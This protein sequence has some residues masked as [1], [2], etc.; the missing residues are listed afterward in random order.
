MSEKRTLCGIAAAFRYTWPGWDEAYA[1]TYHA[2]QIARIAH[3]MGF[4]LQLVP[5]APRDP[6]RTC[7]QMVQPDD[8]N[9]RFWKKAVEAG[10]RAADSLE[11]DDDDANPE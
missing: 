3:A 6:D 7:T 9:Y 10:Q 2:R 11:G 5:L 1:C 8:E 4:Y